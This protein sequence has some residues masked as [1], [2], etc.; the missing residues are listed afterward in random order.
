MPS[1]ISVAILT[2]FSKFFSPSTCLNTRM[3]SYFAKGREME[4]VD[5]QDIQAAKFWR[6]SKKPLT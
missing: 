2:A 1:S 5:F 3:S 6:K 4:F